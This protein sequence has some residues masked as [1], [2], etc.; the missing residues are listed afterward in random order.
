MKNSLWKDIDFSKYDSEDLR[1]GIDTGDKRRPNRFKA[2]KQSDLGD[3]IF[4]TLRHEL[5]S[6]YDPENMLFGRFP[7]EKGLISKLDASDRANLVATADGAGIDIY[8]EPALTAADGV[9][10]PRRVKGYISEI[11]NHAETAEN[12]GIVPAIDLVD[13]EAEIVQLFTHEVERKLSKEDTPFIGCRGGPLFSNRL[14]FTTLRDFSDRKILVNECPKRVN[15][16]RY[17]EVGRLSLEMLYL[18]KRAQIILQ[19]HHFPAPYDNREEFDLLD[20]E[21]GVYQETNIANAESALPKRLP[22]GNRTKNHFSSNKTYL[23][24]FNE[25]HNELIIQE[26]IEEI[27]ETEAETLAEKKPEIFEGLIELSRE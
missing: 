4:D 22:L 21:D 14:P 10:T 26:H 18:L 2:V 12:M 23:N 6:A 27:R 7:L 16:H 15:Y 19:K 24:D 11:K 5:R 25:L 20:A 13:A 8:V 17:D 9:I 1:A 3:H